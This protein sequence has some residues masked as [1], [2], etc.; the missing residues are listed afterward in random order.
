MFQNSVQNSSIKILSKC[1]SCTV[2]TWDPTEGL[3]TSSC[4]P[5]AMGFLL[6]S[7]VPLLQGREKVTALLASN[8]KRHSWLLLKSALSQLPSLQSHA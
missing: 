5:R 1:K 4:W 3:S 2:L 6:S 7:C 8:A